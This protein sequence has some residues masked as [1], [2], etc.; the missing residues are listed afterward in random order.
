MAKAVR[1]LAVG[2]TNSNLKQ[3]FHI[4]ESDLAAQRYDELY[5]LF[6][7]EWPDFPPLDTAKQAVPKPLVALTSSGALAGGLAFVEAKAPLSEERAIWINGV[8]VAPEYRRRGLASQ[9]ISTAEASA[10]QLG[11]SRLYAL[12]ELPVLYCK[13]NWSILSSHGIDFIMLLELGDG[14]K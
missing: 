2:K 8:L 12:T 4:A 14:G 7:K 5:Q 10:L 1:K 13:L 9:L 6:Q 11:I 3:S